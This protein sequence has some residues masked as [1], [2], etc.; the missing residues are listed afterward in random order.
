MAQKEE[1]SNG[2]ARIVASL[3]QLTAKNLWIQLLVSS[4]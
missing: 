1:S 4:E 3:T 2:D